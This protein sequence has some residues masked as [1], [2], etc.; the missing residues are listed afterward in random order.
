[1]KR[2][3]YLA[4]TIMGSNPAVP[5]VAALL[6]ATVMVSPASASHCADVECGDLD[7]SGSITVSDAFRLLR[8]AVAL[9][10]ELVCPYVCSDVTTT[11]TM[12]EPALCT[13][14][15]RLA[16]NVA[17]LSAE[18]DVNYA[19]AS[20]D[21]VG[22]GTAVS[23]AEVFAGETFDD[24]AARRLSAVLIGDQFGDTFSGPTDLL[25]CEFDGVNPTQSQF[26]VDFRDA[27]RAT[28]GLGSAGSGVC[29]A[30]V[31]GLA[32]PTVR[33]ALYVFRAGVGQPVD[34]PLCECD[35]LGD[36]VITATD[37]LAVLNAALGARDDLSC[38]ACD[39]SP[40]VR[41][42]GDPVSIIVS[43]IL[44][45]TPNTSTTTVM[46]PTTTTTSTTSTTLGASSCDVTFRLAENI[47]V[48]TAEFDVDYAAAAGEFVGEGVAV[49]CSLQL[50]EGWVGSF[51]DHDGET[52]LSAVIYPGGLSYSQFGGPV[53]LVTCGFEGAIPTQGQFAVAFR[54][55]IRDRASLGTTGSGVCGAPVTG[56]DRPT[57]R[58]GFAIF[59][60]VVSVGECPLC[61]CD[62]D[63]SGT[64]TASEFSATV[65][66]ALGNPLVEPG[67]PACG[68]S[69]EVR[70]AG[71]PVSIIVSDIICF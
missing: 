20:G 57:M 53:D 49:D 21:F 37:G 66:A 36:G 67:C 42:G 62:L 60:Q 38:P 48:V 64:V 39:Y 69:P 16:E 47:D 22:E 1:M 9:E 71:D 3:G 30:P 11:T 6:A 12:G 45:L 55:A 32:R 13:I 5:L 70:G 44:C 40:E 8:K 31:T 68:Y 10:E 33:D 52:V 61:E 65:N 59:E 35:V 54:D 28:D 29:G 50:P 63:D 15:F 26:E 58:D 7:G 43:D 56:L 24:D 14:T 19:G 23:C 46:A 17:L 18:F 51:Y 25:T 41:G 27:V 2:A 4:T 34:C